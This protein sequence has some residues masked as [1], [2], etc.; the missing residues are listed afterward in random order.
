[1][2]KD[3][4]QVPISSATTATFYQQPSDFLQAVNAVYNNLRGY[5]DRLMFLSE[6]RSDD[7]YP[8]NSDGVARDHDPINNFQTNIPTNVYVEEAWR[9]DFNGIFNANTVLDQLAK[10]GSYAGSPA[11]VTRLTAEAKFLRAFFYFDLVK[12]YG[13]LPIID[14]PATA[15]EA[16]AISRSSV[17]DVYAFIIDDLQ[18]AVANLPATYSGAFPAYS[19]SD[20]GRAN[21]YAA[22]A[23]LAKVYMTRSGPDYGIAGPGLGLNEWNLALPLL[24]DIINSGSYAFNPSF[25]SIFS[26]A[27]QNP[28]VNKEAVFDIMFIKGQN[29]ILG[30]DFPWLLSPQNYFNSFPTGNTAANGLIGNPNVSY[31]LLN[32]YDST[33][34]RLSPTIHTTPFSYNGTVDAHP[35]LRKYL[36]TTQIPTSRFDWGINFIAVRYTD[37]LMLKAECI[38][39][40]APGAQ[41]DVDDIVNQ[42]RARAGLDPLSGV[43]LEQ[44]YDERRREFANEGSRWFD[45]QRS[46]NLITIMNAWINVEDAS[47]HKMSQVTPNDI[48]Y[49]VPQTQLDAAPGLYDQNPGY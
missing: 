4:N 41:G 9:S 23:I 22:E 49:P 26:Y 21:K 27:N 34:A 47:L 13:K 24:Q 25:T 15:A 3:L 2:N 11:L 45:L 38:L 20:V 32:D 48:I 10:N 28:S 36:D 19:S 5:P 39:Q 18:F 44:L 31:D 14:H 33:D 6:V 37:V 12:Y 35:F 17:A 42:V 30:T 43:T 40:G 16:N 8:A 1:C 29:P 7:I 46:G